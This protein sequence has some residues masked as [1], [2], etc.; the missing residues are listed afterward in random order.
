MLYGA[1]VPDIFRGSAVLVG[2]IPIGGHET[3][4]LPVELP[5]KFELVIDLE[6]R[7]SARPRDAL[8]SCRKRA[9]EVIR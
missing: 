7:Q 9:D 4:D 5:T 2:R 8:G 3:L 6:Y 1:D